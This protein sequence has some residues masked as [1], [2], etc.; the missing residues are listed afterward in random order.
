MGRSAA[1]STSVQA[2]I[3]HRF[4]YLVPRGLACDQ[5]Q[6]HGLGLI[7]RQLLPAARSRLQPEPHRAAHDRPVV[8]IHKRSVQRSPAAGNALQYPLFPRAVLLACSPLREPSTCGRESRRTRSDFAG[9][10]PER[11]PRGGV[12]TGERGLTV[13]SHG[14]A[15]ACGCIDASA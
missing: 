7:A 13:V 2:R 15:I 14:L 12:L 10:H 4:W 9:R 8:A 5:I 1:A 6:P 11:S 3:P